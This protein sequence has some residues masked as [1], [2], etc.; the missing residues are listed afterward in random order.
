MWNDRPAAEADTASGRD[1]VVR[2]PEVQHLGHH[3]VVLESTELCSWTW[4]TPE[5][6]VPVVVLHGSGQNENT[7]LRFARAA[8]PGHTVIAVRGRIAW[9]EG[10]A[11]FRRNPDRSLDQTDLA[12]GAAAIQRLL[13]GLQDEYSEPPILLGYSNGAIAAAAAI[14]EAPDLSAG[15]ILLRPLSPFP[16]RVFP[17]LD[18]YPVLLV[19]GEGD[20]RRNPSDGPTLARQFNFAGAATSLVVLPGGHGLTIADENAVTRWL[21]EVRSQREAP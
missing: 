11:F 3:G 4:S 14:L 17:P 2:T 18:G 20:T 16:E 10:F 7:L 13:E 8:C 15:A 19:S 12:H 1:V 21:P 6:L 9:E 5:N